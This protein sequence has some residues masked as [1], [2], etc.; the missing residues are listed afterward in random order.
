VDVKGNYRVP[1]QSLGSLTFN[2]EG[3][4]V[5]ELLTQPLTGGPSYDCMGYEGQTCGAGQPKWRHVLNTTWSTPWDGLDFNIRWRYIGAVDSDTTSANPLLN[6]NLT[7]P[8]TA[9]I[10]AYNYIDL[11]TSF[12][13]TKVVRMQLGVNNLADKVPPLITGADNAGRPLGRD[14][15]E[16]AGHGARRFF[17]PQEN[18]AGAPGM[19]RGGRRSLQA[20]YPVGTLGGRIHDERPKGGASH[21]DRIAGRQQRVRI[22]QQLPHLSALERHGRPPL[23]RATE[24]DHPGH[25]RLGDHRL[26]MFHGIQPEGLRGIGARGGRRRGG[27]S[28]DGGGHRRCSRCHRGRGC[29]RTAGDRVVAL[30]ASG[31][32]LNGRA[33]A[34]RGPRLLGQRRTTAERGP[35]QQRQARPC[36][37]AHSESSPARP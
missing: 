4:R 9:N 21:R 20:M 36:R 17:W 35:G 5:I 26:G 31:R 15:L 10:P 24:G 16:T 11:E 3:T 13:I 32:V 29:R 2:L 28:G 14:D 1:M 33:V 23:R 30:Q 8:P 34:E 18:A 12:A 25:E 27:G 6:K 7:P 22:V 19:A 37:A